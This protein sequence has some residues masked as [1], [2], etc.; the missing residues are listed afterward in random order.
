M[1][2]PNTLRRSLSLGF[3][4]ALLPIKYGIG[5]TPKATIEIWKSPTCGCCHDWM[6]HM[7]SNGFVIGKV[8]DDGNDVARKSW[9]LAF[10]LAHAIP[11]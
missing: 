10:N 9:V 5:A 8:H 1:N 2:T 7:T 6:N 4:F 11:P 3:L